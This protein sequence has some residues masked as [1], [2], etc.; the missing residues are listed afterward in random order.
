MV[1]N[2]YDADVRRKGTGF[3]MEIVRRRLAASFGD[4][5]ALTAEARDG[6]YRVSI[7]I[8]IE[9]TVPVP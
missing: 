9:P 2:P 6:Q 3:G 1:T 8:P 7:T 4:R 5:A